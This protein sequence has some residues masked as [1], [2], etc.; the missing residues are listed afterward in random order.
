MDPATKGRTITK[1]YS[2]LQDSA[3]RPVDAHLPEKKD[4][5]ILI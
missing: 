5:G 3:N 1:P 4:E 2:Q